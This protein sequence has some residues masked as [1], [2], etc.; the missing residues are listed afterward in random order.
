MR[1]F[2]AEEQAGEGLAI[3][4]FDGPGHELGGDFLAGREDRLGQFLPVHRAGDHRQIR[5]DLPTMVGLVAFFSLFSGGKAL[6]S[7]VY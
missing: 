6:R 7:L 2:F 1:K 5:A 4:G 3:G